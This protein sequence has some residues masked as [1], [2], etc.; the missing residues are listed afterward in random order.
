MKTRERTKRNVKHWRGK[1]LKSYIKSLK[2]RG[3]HEISDD[4][5]RIFCNGFNVGYK[6][7]RKRGTSHKDKNG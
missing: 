4:E 5:S 3:L 1:A 2:E 7:G 6:E